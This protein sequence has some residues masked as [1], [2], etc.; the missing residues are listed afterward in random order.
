[1]DA[2][3]PG[4]SALSCA[5]SNYGE[6]A[7]VKNFRVRTPIQP[8][9]SACPRSNQREYSAEPAGISGSPGQDGAVQVSSFVFQIR[10]IQV[11]GLVPQDRAVQ[12]MR[13]LDEEKNTH[14]G[15][16]G[17]CYEMD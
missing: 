7:A 12:V 3:A 5:N 8:S 17:K 15:K 2:P 10:A 13:E 4:R 1:V 9:I 14:Q 6:F 16:K 11:S